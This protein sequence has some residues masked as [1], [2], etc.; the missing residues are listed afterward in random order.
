MTT[1]K[2]EHPI[3]KIL[4][5][6]D[7]P[8]GG[9]A[10]LR[11]HRLVMDS[12]AWGHH[13]NPTA[14]P[15]IGKL[16]YLADARFVPKGETG[17]HPHREVDVISVM[18]E[19]RIA[20]GGTLE[21]GQELEPFDVQVQ[22]AGG[23]GFSHNETNPDDTENRMIQLWVLPE[24]SGQP[25]GYKLFKPRWGAVTRVYGGDSEQDKTFPGQTHMDVALL[26]GGQQAAFEGPFLAY[27]TKGK[28]A[29]NGMS[30]ADGDLMRGD[31]LSFEAIEDAQL[32][33]VHLGS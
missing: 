25:A 32:I 21:H 30:A 3:V 26:R 19:G 1:T 9:F 24:V 33:V 11:E 20:H 13:V 15:G 5:R 4:H 12:T 14:W 16:V 2:S 8:L 29:A 7:S 31:G 27:I 10:G 18:V 28:G 22:R 23:E 17:M 6:D